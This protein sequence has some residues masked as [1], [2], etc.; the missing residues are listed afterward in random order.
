[1]RTDPV[2]GAFTRL[3]SGI[4]FQ[5]GGC[6]GPIWAA[7]TGTVIGVFTDQYGGWTL[8]VDHDGVI[9]RYKHMY[10]SG[11]LV[12]VGDQVEAGQQI[13]RTGNSGWSTG[14]HLHFE[15]H[16]DGLPVNPREFLAELGITL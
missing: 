11:V 1:M 8:D 3:H 9:T 4:D 15:I 16:V 6:G 14:C 2:T 10:V 7:Q 12:A 5:A 13:A